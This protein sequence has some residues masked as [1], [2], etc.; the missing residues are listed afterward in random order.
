M[1]LLGLTLRNNLSWKS[2][3]KSNVKRALKKLWAIQRLKRHGA[4]LN[5]LVDIFVKEVRSILEIGFPVWNSGF[6]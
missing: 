4:N 2:N 3:T 5:D 1:E 6:G